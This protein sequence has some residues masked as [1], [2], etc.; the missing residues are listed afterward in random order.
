MQQLPRVYFYCRKEEGN[1][2]EDVITL[3]EGLRELG[4]PFSG[5]CDYWLESP[6]SGDYLIRHNP[7]IS[8][9]DAD[10]VVVSYTW[11]FWIRMNTFDLVRRPLPEGLFKTGRRYR[12]V[13]M[14]SHDGHRTV[15]WEPEFRQFDLILRS[16]LNQRAWHP[17]NMKPWVLGFTNRVLKATSG[18]APFDKRNRTILINFGASHPYPHGTR[19]VAART[20]ERKI[21]KVLSIDRT[22]DDLEKEPSDPYDALMWRQTGGRYSREYYER[23]KNAQTAA[24]FCGE[25]I[26]PMPY[27]QP[28]CYLVG[29][30]KAKLR[31]R[32]Y[33]LLANFDLRPPRSVQW[34]SFRFWETLCAGA[35]AFNID[36]ERYGSEIPV[37]PHN[38]EHYIGVD[39]D[40]VGEVIERL[41]AEP[42]L[43]ARIAAAG[44]RWALKNYS[45][46]AMAERFLTLTGLCFA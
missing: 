6:T 37:M 25:L 13:Y 40:R 9:D 35:V 7:D 32:F 38:W 42:E 10:V 36:L 30:N 11:P 28:E 27:R 20:F 18:G 8:V 16:K 24:C 1:L 34:D 23:L 15:S 4:I 19:E 41:A 33:E 44:C 29:G 26:P 3:A 31:R 14:D 22:K 12:T 46:K 45:P 17:E 43:L 5:N 39:F 21:Q 2:Q